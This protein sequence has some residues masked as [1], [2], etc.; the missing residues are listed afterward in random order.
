MNLS[1][2]L[3]SSLNSLLDA[4]GGIRHGN[5]AGYDWSAGEKGLVELEPEHEDI[6]GVTRFDHN[7]AKQHDLAYFRAEAKLATDLR[8][9]VPPSLAHAEYHA[10]MARADIKFVGDATENRAVGNGLEEIPEGDLSLWGEIV[11]GLGIAAMSVKAVGHGSLSLT[12]TVDGLVSQLVSTT[13][14]DNES[15]SPPSTNILFSENGGGLSDIG[16]TTPATP[17]PSPSTPPPSTPSFSENGGGLFDIGPTTPAHGLGADGNQN[18]DTGP[19]DGGSTTPAHD[20]GSDGNQNDDTGTFDD[21]NSGDGDGDG[22]GGDTLSGGSAGDVLSGDAGADTLRGNGGDD[23]LLGGEDNDTLEGGAGSNVLYGSADPLRGGT[24]RR[25]RS[26]HSE[27]VSK[28]PVRAAN[29][30]FRPAA[31]GF[32]RGS[33]RWMWHWTSARA[34]TA[35]R[36]SWSVLCR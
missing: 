23:V 19:S 31:V 32:A 18:D 15:K 12:Y 11:R 6:D 13:G 20:L 36:S 3:P 9:G 10:A 8:N 4:I 5:W 14:T 2:L 24:D 33:T 34:R 35:A 29:C 26:R 22:G 25:R 17:N 1:A 21:G 30:A 16:P 28:P 27:N 7:A